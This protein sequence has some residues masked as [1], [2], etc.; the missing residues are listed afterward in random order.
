MSLN[1]NEIKKKIIDKLQNNPIIGHACK[2]A[3]VARS[4]F[5]RFREEDKDFD[6]AI[7]EAQRIG[8][9][10]TCDAA[11]SKIL[12]LINSD[13]EDI[14]LKASKTV[15]NTYNHRYQNNN[16]GINYQKTILKNEIEKSE[17][18][19]NEIIDTFSKLL[20]L[21]V[22][23]VSKENDL[24]KEDR[25]FELK[26][27]LDQLLKKIKGSRENIQNDNEENLRGLI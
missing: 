2:N 21:A 17:H 24:N 25:L 13:N 27:T 19:K 22:D 1:Q 10:V 6:K 8:R 7:K 11:E 3:G 18:E 4:T 23:S 12:N 15:L 14:A 9:A 26:E 20:S 5:Y 16:V